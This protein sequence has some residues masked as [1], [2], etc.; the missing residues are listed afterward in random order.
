MIL[1]IKLWWTLEFLR[2]SSPISQHSLFMKAQNVHACKMP[3]LSRIF[4]TVIKR[5]FSGFRGR[6]YLN[7]SNCFSIY[8]SHLWT[9]FKVLIKHVTVWRNLRWAYP[10]VRVESRFQPWLICSWHGSESLPSRQS[11]FGPSKKTHKNRPIIAKPK[12]PAAWWKLTFNGPKISHCWKL[13]QNTELCVEIK[14]NIE[15]TGSVAT[16]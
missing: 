14:R 3:R 13:F 12:T 6:K 4:Q 9:F 16:C 11:A 5:Q 2:L 8:K 10:A 15:R 7:S 1:W